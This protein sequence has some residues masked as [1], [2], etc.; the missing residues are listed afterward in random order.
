MVFVNQFES[1]QKFGNKLSEINLR[2]LKKLKDFHSKNAK[3]YL[4]YLHC[5]GKIPEKAQI[6]QG[7]VSDFK[8]NFLVTKILID[9]GRLGPSF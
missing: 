1:F 8:R 4:T 2:E 7:P 3:F 9:L 5:P 6:F